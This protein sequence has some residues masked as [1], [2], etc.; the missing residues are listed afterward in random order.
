[1]RQAFV[2]SLFI[3]TKTH[4]NIVL[5]TGDLGFTVFEKYQKSF[6]DNF[7]N[8]GVMEANMVG[9]ASGLA[10]SG[11]IP[12]VYSIAPFVTLRTY[13]QIRNDV[14]LHNANVKIIGVGSGLSYTHA[15]PSHHVLEDLAVMRAL[16]NMTVVSP[17]DPME[18]S[19]CMKAAIRQPGPV[20]IR[21]GKK[22]EPVIHKSKP[23]F[24]FGKGIIVKRGGDIYIVTCGPIIQTVI[25]ASKILESWH[26][27]CGVVSM[28]TIKPLDTRLIGKLSKQVKGLFT[29]EEHSIIGGL[30]GAVSEYLAENNGT[31]ILFKRFGTR[32]TFCLEIGDH[33]YM[34]DKQ[35]LSA[36]KIASSIRKTLRYAK[37]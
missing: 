37:N 32:D 10:L 34:R 33:D 7:Y 30:G 15:G 20:Y 14:C 4:K 13:E 1:M 17:S 28:H 27:S 16:P 8:A 24:S 11:K 26:I 36:I 22:G 3:L 19:L 29:V 23:D 31:N 5:L 25:E 6:P 12:F 2:D 21:L 35:N 18:V 9:V